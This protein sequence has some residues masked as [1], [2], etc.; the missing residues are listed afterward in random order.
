MQ[1]CALIRYLTSDEPKEGIVCY[2][3]EFGLPL[4]MYRLTVMYKRSLQWPAC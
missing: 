1:I 4:F 3:V 2:V